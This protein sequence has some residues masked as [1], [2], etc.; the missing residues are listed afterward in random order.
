MKPQACI[1]CAALPL[2]QQPR[3]PRVTKGG[4]RSKRCATHR[5]AWERAVRAKRAE[6]RVQKV[7][8]LGPGE[9]DE[10]LAYQGGTCAIPGCPANGTARRLAV[11]H[12]H[13]TGEPRGILCQPHNFD[14]LGK[15][16]G[17]LQAAQ[18]YLIDPPLRRM[19][20][21]RQVDL[22]EAA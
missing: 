15:F 3:T 19:R 20:R 22:N 12:D 16:A 7:Y 5:R 18:D 2:S 21:E 9:Y 13:D 11:D 14:L 8:G 10:L 17:D 4:P 6:A 1:D